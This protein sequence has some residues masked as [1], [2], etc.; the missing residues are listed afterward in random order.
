MGRSL[1]YFTVVEHHIDFCRTCWIVRRW[2]WKGNRRPLKTPNTRIEL[3]TLGQ[4]E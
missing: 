2:H 1:Y 4:G 3:A